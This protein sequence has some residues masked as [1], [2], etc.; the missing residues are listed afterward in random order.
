MEYGVE[1]IL[2]NQN[3]LQNS[4]CGSYYLIFVLVEI[5]FSR[6]MVEGVREG[7]GIPVELWLREI[8]AYGRAPSRRL[9][10]RVGGPSPTVHCVGAKCRRKTCGS[11]QSGITF[12]ESSYIRYYI[13]RKIQTQQHLCLTSN[14]FQM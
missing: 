7:T 10:K 3:N 12:V 5:T 13:R 11:T 8:S 6:I 14:D 9:L 1:N 4:I 2:M